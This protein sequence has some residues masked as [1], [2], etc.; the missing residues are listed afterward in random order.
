MDIT[1]LPVLTILI[2]RRLQNAEDLEQRYEDEL[3]SKCA[4]V[5]P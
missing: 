2:G 3:S 1:F 5:L 4:Q